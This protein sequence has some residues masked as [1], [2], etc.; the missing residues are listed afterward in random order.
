MP[1]CRI[2]SIYVALDEKDKAYEELNKA[3]EAK[4]WELHRLKADTYWN[5][6]RNDARF[7]EMLKR[8]NLPE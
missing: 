3:F 7:K 1:T 5:P 8:L 2:A 6:L 4:D